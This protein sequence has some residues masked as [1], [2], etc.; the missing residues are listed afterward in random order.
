MTDKYEKVDESLRLTRWIRKKFMARDDANNVVLTQNGEPQY[1]FPQAYQL[2]AV[3]N[4][5]SL[6]NIDHFSGADDA[7][8][9]CA[10]EA[11]RTSLD[12]KKINAQDAFSLAQCAEIKNTCSQHGS[13]VRILKNPVDGN[14]AHCV[15]TSFPEGLSLL[16]EELANQ[17]FSTKKLYR[18][19]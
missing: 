19:L 10:A 8:L 12:S 5:L 4:D 6:S 3:E 9:K 17:T 18:D 16:H 13:K 11:T 7:R 2:R 14:D 15:V 1:V